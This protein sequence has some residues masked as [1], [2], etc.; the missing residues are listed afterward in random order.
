MKNEK[1][2]NLVEHLRKNVFIVGVENVG[3]ENIDFLFSKLKEKVEK[4]IV[5]K[6]IPD[7]PHHWQ[8]QY[9]PYREIC[10]ISGAE[11]M[12]WNQLKEKIITQEEKSEH[13]FSN[14]KKVK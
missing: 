14:E 5:P 7:Y 13:N 10:D 4:N 9:C 11:E 6:R 12:D 1:L 8:C 3:I 2:K